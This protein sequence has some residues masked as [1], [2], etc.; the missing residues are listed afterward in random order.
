MDEDTYYK[1]L[2]EFLSNNTY[3]D[4]DHRWLPS[5]TV[6]RAVSHCC[7]ARRCR[8]VC[9]QPATASDVVA[10][11]DTLQLSRGKVDDKGKLQVNAKYAATQWLRSRRLGGPCVSESH[12]ARVEQRNWPAGIFLHA[13]D[14]RCLGS[15][16]LKQFPR[17]D[18]RPDGRKCKVTLLSVDD[19]GVEVLCAV[20]YATLLMMRMT[21]VTMFMIMM[22]LGLRRLLYKWWR[23]WKTKIM[24]YQNVFLLLIVDSAALAGRGDFVTVRE[25]L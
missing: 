8:A 24:L 18:T 11:C 12:R 1:E 9:W 19:S 20:V 23:C 15:G 25:S 14:A 13:A 21:L 7:V 17:D 22:L 3:P 6:Y 16:K 2:Y 10:V 5:C 4:I